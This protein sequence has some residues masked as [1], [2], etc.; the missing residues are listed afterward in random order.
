MN[1]ITHRAAQRLSSLDPAGTVFSHYTALAIKHQAVNLG[2]GFPTLPVAPFIRDAAAKAIASEC[3]GH[4]YTRSEGHVRLA[5][6]LAG[7]YSGKLDRELN[8]LTEIMTTVGAS[9]AIYSSIQSLVNPG[10]EVILMQPYYDSYPASIT[11]AGGVPVVVSLS[12]KSNATTSNDWLLDMNSLRNAITSKTKIIM[13]NNP[14][15]P[16]GKV[17][18]RPELQQIANIAKEFDL[19]VIADEV[20]ETLVYS[21]S[22][23]PMIKFASLPGMYE[24]TI[25]IGSMGKMFGVTGWKIGWCIAP[26]ELIRAAWMVHQFLPFTVVTPLQEAGAESLE[27]AMTNGYFEE[28]IKQYQSL[29]DQLMETLQKVG[30]KPMK[31]DGGY[32]II[33]DIEKYQTDEDFSTYLTKQAGVTSIPMRAFYSKESQSLVDNYARFAFCKDEK[34]LSDAGSRLQTFYQTHLKDKK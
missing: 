10:D 17:W 11:L 6:A 3:M 15:N 2:Q 12:A 31:P 8:H 27:K 13:I 7:Y 18:T 26:P 16:V 20:Y 23:S 24:R 1:K 4:Q 30:F 34:T 32:F 14:N 22:A 5:K 21:D 19:L 9:E 25:T 29:R 28:T 33:T